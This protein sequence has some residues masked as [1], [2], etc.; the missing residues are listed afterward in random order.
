MSQVSQIYWHSKLPMRS[1][2]TKFQREL[3]CDNVTFILY[4]YVVHILCEYGHRNTV[5]INYILS[6]LKPVKCSCLYNIVCFCSYSLSKGAMLSQ[7]SKVFW[8][9]IKLKH[10]FQSFSRCVSWHTCVAIQILYNWHLYV[11]CNLIMLFSFYVFNVNIY[12]SFKHFSLRFILLQIRKSVRHLSFPPVCYISL[13]VVVVFE[14]LVFNKVISLANCTSQ[15]HFELF[16]KFSFL[17]NN[18]INFQVCNISRKLGQDQVLGFQFVYSHDK[19][20]FY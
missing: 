1:K 2:I 12:F 6:F 10:N 11:K 19:D 7:K 14:T 4:I 18:L 17:N 15:T 20:D 13:L 5:T 8:E 16:L 3:K 9:D